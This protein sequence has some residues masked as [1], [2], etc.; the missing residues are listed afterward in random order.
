[1][2]YADYALYSYDA[3]VYGGVLLFPAA[4][5][6]FLRRRHLLGDRVI[7][8]TLKYVR[9]CGMAGLGFASVMVVTCDQGFFR[10]Y[11]SQQP[12]QL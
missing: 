10:S 8:N 2:H 1:M 9:A 12:T 4:P 7:V 6:P 11:S 5:G 3:V